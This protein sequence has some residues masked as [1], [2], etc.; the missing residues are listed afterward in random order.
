MIGLG[1]GIAGVKLGEHGLYVR[2][3]QAARLV[4]GPGVIPS[5][6]ADREL[7]S[8]VFETDVVGT[9]GAGDATI[10]GFLFGLLKGMSPGATV[11]AACAV[12][13]SSTEAADGT[14]SVP[15]WPE[16]ERR[17]RRGWRRKAATPGPGW[18]PSREPG[19]WHGP[20]DAMGAAPELSN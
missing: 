16:I 7:Y 12:G 19:L 20:R 15:S 5:A 14:S 2:S 11:T 17:L 1:V 3:A 6:W 18:S 4:V 13:G 9:T 8:S 10:A